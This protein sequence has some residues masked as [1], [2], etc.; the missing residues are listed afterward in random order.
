MGH[1]S[2]VMLR[3]SGTDLKPFVDFFGVASFD[4]VWGYD[5]TVPRVDSGR[6][7]SADAP[8]EVLVTRT[9]AERLDLQPGDH[10]S[11]D[12]LT[13]AKVFEFFETGGIPEPDGPVVE[14]TVTGVGLIAPELVAKEQIPNGVI[15]FT[16]AFLETYRDLAA[17]SDLIDVKLVGGTPAIASFVEDATDIFGTRV[18]VTPI[19]EELDQIRPG[20]TSSAP[21]C[22]C[23]SQSP[24]SPR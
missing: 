16:P 21:R 22:C 2:I 1:H 8:A 10:F 19:E 20:S 7:P 24:A 6:M 3:P 12:T 14:L 17:F 23:S 11:V 18:L 4:G 9:L 13:M 5:L 15:V